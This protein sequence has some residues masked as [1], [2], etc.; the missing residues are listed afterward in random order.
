M[1]FPVK[2]VT[3]LKAM[4]RRVR[5]LGC[6]EKYQCPNSQTLGLD[7]IETLDNRFQRLRIRPLNWKSQQNPPD[8]RAS[9]LHLLMRHLRRDGQFFELEKRVHEP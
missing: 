3:H 7:Y 8:L 4:A 6:F 9:I 1:L 2:N 5:I